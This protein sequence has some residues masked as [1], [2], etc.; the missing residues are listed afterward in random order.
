MSEKCLVKE[1][2]FAGSRVGTKFDDMS[3]LNKTMTRDTRLQS[4]EV[5]VTE[6]SKLVTSFRLILAKSYGIGDQGEKLEIGGKTTSKCKQFQLADPIGDPITQITLY[7]N[8]FVVHGLQ[9]ISAKKTGAFGNTNLDQTVSF[10]FTPKTPL[11]GIYG[12][13]GESLINGMSVIR[14]DLNPECQASTTTPTNVGFEEVDEKAKAIA[15]AA[16]AAAAAKNSTEIVETS[17]QPGKINVL[18][19]AAYVGGAVF[20]ILIILVIVVVVD[21]CRRKRKRIT[22]VVELKPV[23]IEEHFKG[24]EERNKKQLKPAISPI[25]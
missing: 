5:C 19:I 16:A 6:D 12:N 2:V 15:A 13:T 24:I 22:E 20:L 21:K 17:E 9:I 11:I 3:L 18:V 25:H 14:F 4:F 23:N 7:I 1:K 8:E 10:T